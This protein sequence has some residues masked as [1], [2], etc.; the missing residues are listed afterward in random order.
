ML[1]NFIERRNLLSNAR[2]AMAP[3]QLA[4]CGVCLTFATPLCCALFAQKVSISIDNLEPEVK[5]EIL[6]QDPTANILFYN[7]GL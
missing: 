7:K 5:E 2:W 3:L 4:L 6:N 1:T